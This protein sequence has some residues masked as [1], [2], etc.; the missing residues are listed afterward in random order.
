MTTSA[1]T[2]RRGAGLVLLT[3]AAAQFLMVL[4]SSVMNVSIGVVA[5]DIG[6]TVTGIQTAITFYALVMA[7]LMITGGKLGTMYGRR[8]IF[9]IGLVVY[10][11]GS[12][13]TAIAPNLTVLIIGW[14]VLE[15]I[16]GALILPAIVALVATNFGPDQRPRAYG[17]VMAAAAAAVA[18]GPVIGGLFTTYLSWRLVFA[19]ELLASLAILV[20]ARRMEDHPT[21]EPGRLDL[22]GTA[23]SAL[24]LGLIVFGV[25]RS[26]TWGLVRPRPGGPAWIGLSPVIVLIAAGGAVLVAFVAWEQRRIDTGK[27]ALFDPAMLRIATLRSGLSAFGYQ[28]FLQAGLFFTIPLFLSVALGLSAVATGVR[29]LPLSVVLTVTALGLPKL[30][31][32]ASPRRVVQAGFLLIF[33]GIALLVALLEVGSGPAVITWPMLVIGAGIGA[34]SSQLGA[35]TVG[36]VPDEQSSEVGGLQNTVTNFG[37]SIGTALAGAILIAALTTTFLGGLK[38]DPDVPAALADRAQVELAGGV[39]FVSDADL[40]AALHDV[41]VAPAVVDDVVATNAD[42]RVTGLR[43]ALAVLALVALLAWWSAR[44]LPTEPTGGTSAPLA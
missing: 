20:V 17:A 3:L 14:S 36:A 13:V 24:G 1:A 30:R 18:A 32:Q 12:V 37:A 15:G 11:T 41:G 31:P 10:G 40:E 21:T 4:D 33:V 35:V 2:A 16:G 39:P 23:V 19:S 38:T 9:S 34:M 8:R 6:T 26:G 44:S 7:T 43:A 28:F 5:K 25:L 22:V 27:P 29:L 42:A